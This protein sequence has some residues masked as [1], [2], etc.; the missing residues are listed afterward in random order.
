[1]KKVVAEKLKEGKIVKD[2]LLKIKV[3]ESETDEEVNMVD[4]LAQIG[5]KKKE[6]SSDE[7]T[8]G[9]SMFKGLRQGVQ[10]LILDKKLLEQ[11]KKEAPH[12]NE[13]DE[14][15]KKKRNKFLEKEKEE[16]RKREKVEREKA[17]E[18]AI[19]VHVPNDAKVVEEMMESRNK[20]TEI[21]SLNCIYS[22]LFFLF[23]L[24]I[25]QAGESQNIME[26]L[27]FQTEEG[28]L[29]DKQHRVIRYNMF[30]C[31]SQCQDPK[32]K[33]MCEAFS[34]ETYLYTCPVDEVDPKSSKPCFLCQ[35]KLPPDCGICKDELE[36]AEEKGY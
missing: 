29:L 1:M 21:A 28:L 33:Q 32:E 20:S 6:L 19:Y 18:A 11:Q 4:F 14:E 22:V 8:L 25:F 30:G 7:P 5:E 35:S 16:Q 3:D 13:T 9:S 23:F 34:V 24:L 2:D 31:C 10:G 15:E 36:F 26:T 27:R 12:E 17:E